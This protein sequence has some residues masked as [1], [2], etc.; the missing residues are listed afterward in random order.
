[1]NTKQE[2]IE[3]KIKDYIS[4][5]IVKTLSFIFLLFGGLIF[6]IYYYSIEYIPS[7]NLIT[8]VQLLVTASVTGLLIVSSIIA[9][10][11]LPS[12]FWE[13]AINKNE[14][15][16][17]VGIDRS[18]RILIF[19]AIPML[20]VNGSIIASFYSQKV[21]ILTFNILWLVGLG[22][23]ILIVNK[24][25]SKNI[26]LYW[27]YFGF[28]AL[29]AYYTVTS[30]LPIFVLSF[31]FFETSV[32]QV[33]KSISINCAILLVIVTTINIIILFK[34]EKIGFIYWNS[35]LGLVSFVMITTLTNTAATFPKAI[36][37]TYKL[38]NIKVSSLVL[39]KQ[40]CTIVNESMKFHQAKDK[41]GEILKFEINNDICTVPDVL[42]LSRL[43]EESYIEKKTQT[44]KYPSKKEETKCNMRFPLSLIHI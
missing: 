33:I 27:S 3:K 12:F 5:N 28:L 16:I 17:F 24:Q 18:Q 25:N 7:F 42:I 13:K 8:S 35:V 41:K 1:M 31:I 38:G 2:K 26:N 32:E 43:G 19:F 4:E 20:F 23:Y 34:P 29:S 11:I 44:C 21:W 15:L 30:I 22:I 39:D 10:L 40:G 37:R 36:M 14:G 9:M 6:F